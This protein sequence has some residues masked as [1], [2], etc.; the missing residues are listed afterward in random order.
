[1]ADD[2]SNDLA[3]LRITKQESAPSKRAWWPWLAVVAFVAVGASA[4]T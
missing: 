4:H 1:M 3:S 2:L